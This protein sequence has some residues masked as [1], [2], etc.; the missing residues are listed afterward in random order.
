MVMVDDVGMYCHEC[1]FRVYFMRCMCI[2]MYFLR[3]N[4]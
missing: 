3:V 2:N 1:M 4:M